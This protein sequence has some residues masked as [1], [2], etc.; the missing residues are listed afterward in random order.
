MAASAT[1]EKKGAGLRADLMRC[2]P[3]GSLVYM[4][5]KYGKPRTQKGVSQWAS[6]AA[7]EA[8]LEGRTVSDGF[9]H[10]EPLLPWVPAGPAG[11]RLQ[12]KLQL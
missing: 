8:G 7:R 3:G 11:D 12:L 10:W 5:T 6:A 4:L 1:A 2:L 9:P